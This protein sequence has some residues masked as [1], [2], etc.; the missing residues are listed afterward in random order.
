MNQLIQEMKLFS[1]ESAQFTPRRDAMAIKNIID[2]PIYHNSGT[3]KVPKMPIQRDS[4]TFYEL[5]DVNYVFLNSKTN[6]D[7]LINDMV[8]FNTSQFAYVNRHRYVTVAVASLTLEDLFIDFVYGNVNL[9]DEAAGAGLVSPACSAKWDRTLKNI[10]LTLDN[11]TASPNIFPHL[12]SCCTT[13]RS[14]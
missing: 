9:G 1:I 6:F 2:D 5:K 7:L 13:V 12:S 11:D 8:I 3:L 10:V 14:T 4:T